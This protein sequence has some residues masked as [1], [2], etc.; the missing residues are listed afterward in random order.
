MGIDL[1]YK[2]FVR[3]GFF[4]RVF[5]FFHYFDFLAD[6]YPAWILQVQN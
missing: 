6:I 5:F 1:F 3:T 2:M 4:P